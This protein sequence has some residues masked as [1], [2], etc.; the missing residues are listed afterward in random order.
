MTQRAPDGTAMLR[1]L[2]ALGRALR[3]TGLDVGPG[4]LQDAV[5]ALGVVGPV[6]RDEAFWALRCCVCTEP[7]HLP[8]FEAAF[9]SFAAGDSEASGPDDRGEPPPAPAAPTAHGEL[10]DDVDAADDER[11]REFGDGASSGE[12]LLEL[13]FAEYQPAEL[14][15]ARRLI[16]SLGRSLPVRRS[17]RLERAWSG[18]HLDMRRTLQQAMRTAGDPLQRAWQRPRHVA[19]RTIFLLDVSGSMAAY[20]RPMLMFAQAAQCVAR[21]VETFA[22]G[23][24]ITR[25]TTHLSGP[26]RDQSLGDAVR[27]VPDWAGGTRIGESLAAYNQRWGS[28]G[29]TRG[30][31]VVIA[32]DGWETGD[33]EVLR[34]EM[35]RL[36]RAAHRLIWVTPSAAD[37]LFQPLTRGMVAATPHIDLL[38]A[39]HNL[40]A[41]GDLAAAFEGLGPAAA[42]SQP[43][44]RPQ[45]VDKARAP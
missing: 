36:H 43:S 24:R 39:S 44:A 32:S 5:R 42:A 29:N 17:F 12:R 2:V 21:S 40:R 28:R 37:P 4:Q 15:E 31:V 11:V 34:T 18:T 10:D 45:R 22:F 38:L 16:E 26:D 41:M 20:T 27:S 7:A 33:V 3:R 35:A 9:R 14:V 8:L 25:L 6:D 23:T 19:R 30:A 1:E 13:D